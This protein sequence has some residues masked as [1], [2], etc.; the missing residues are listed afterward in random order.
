MPQPNG[1]SRIQGYHIRLALFFSALLVTLWDFVM[2]QR[3]TFRLSLMNMAGLGLFLTG[4]FIRVI[5]VRTLGKYFSPKLRTLKDHRLVDYGVY[6]Y[7]RHPAY[8]GTLLFSIGIPLIFS[9]LYGFS[10]MLALFPCYLYRI[11]FEE[12]MLL[13]KLG[14]EYR[15]YMKKAKKII[16]LIY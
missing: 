3:I 2:V 13:E 15:E 9:S 12:R 16:P 4:V 8:L 14:D 5:A 11:K 10:L 6:K 7:I 1:I